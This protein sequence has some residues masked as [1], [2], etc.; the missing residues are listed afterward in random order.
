MATKVTDIFNHFGLTIHGQIKW[1]NKITSTSCGIYIIAITDDRD[2]IVTIDKPIFNDKEINDW[3]NLVS[4]GGKTLLIDK[5]PAT[6]QSIKLRLEQ[7]WLPDET[8]VYIGK[9]GPKVNRTLKKRLEEFYVT[10]L[11][12]NKK[13]AGGH[14]LNTLQNLSDLNIFY[15]EADPDIEED[16]IKYFCGRVSCKTKE[17]L[18]DNINCFPFA[19]KELNKSVRKSH[20]F[21]N[22]TIECKTWKKQ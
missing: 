11:G 4:S 22:Q 6:I 5:V 16:M 1:G 8:I 3:I 18:Y 21:T 13:H 7:F 2:K 15:S 10:R 20:G 12:C 17:Q 9:A 19:N 14:W